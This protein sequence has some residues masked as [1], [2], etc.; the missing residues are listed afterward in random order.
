M[1][2]ITESGSTIITESGDT[3]VEEMTKRDLIANAVKARF[4]TILTTGGYRTDIGGTF[5]RRLI[6]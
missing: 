3:L 1:T 4:E 2:L 6:P 5:I